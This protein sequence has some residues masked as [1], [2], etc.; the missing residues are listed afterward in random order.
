MHWYIHC[1]KHYVDF[2][3]R[4]RRQEYWNFILFNYIFTLILFFLSK[5]SIFFVVIYNLYNIVTILPGLA[6]LTRRL[7]DTGR[8]MVFVFT[9]I[10]IWLGA[11]LFFL[12]SVGAASV[13]MHNASTISNI[14]SLSYVIFIILSIIAFG[15]TIVSFIF[16]LLDSHVA[17]NL[18][19]PSPKYS[20]AT[21]YSPAPTGTTICSLCGGINKSTNTF[22]VH[23]GYKNS[24]TSKPIPRGIVKDQRTCPHCNQSTDADRDFCMKCGRPL[25]VQIIKAE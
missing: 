8:S 25:P 22:C 9:P 6:V 13:S 19:G 10:A 4:A 16:T 14:F 2:N 15:F 24:N 11:F 12:V 7:H 23:C 1:F 5:L 20:N 21:T 3:G 18:Y 17:N